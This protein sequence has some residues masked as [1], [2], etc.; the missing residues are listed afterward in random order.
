[1]VC[2]KYSRAFL[3]PLAA[4]GIPFATNLITYHNVAFMQRLAKQIREAIRENRMPEYV[5]E[6]VKKH[7]PKV[8]PLVGCRFHSSCPICTPLL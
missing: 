7:Y 1:M 3:H 5:R 6:S 4:K 8:C 2:K